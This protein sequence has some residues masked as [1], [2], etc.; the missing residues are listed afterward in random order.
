MKKAFYFNNSSIFEKKPYEKLNPTGRWKLS[1][2]PN[3]Y[4][5]EDDSPILSI[6]HLGNT[7]HCWIDETDIIYTIEEFEYINECST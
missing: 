1:Y 5:I 6:E 7:E 4:I 3:T 2:S